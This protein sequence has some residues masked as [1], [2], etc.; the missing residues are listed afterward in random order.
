ML[1]LVAIIVP[2]LAILLCGKP[3]QAIF[4]LLL[5]IFGLL[6]FIGT[7]GFG[8]GITFVIWIA[9]IAHGMFTV[10]GRNQAARDRALVDTISGDN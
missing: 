7:F 3:F 6:V 8:S 5:L 1:Y 4:N 10:H 2:P 9:C